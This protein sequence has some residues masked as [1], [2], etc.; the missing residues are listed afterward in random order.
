ASARNH[1]P[2]AGTPVPAPAGRPHGIP[3][4]SPV[5]T[6]C[7]GQRQADDRV[8]IWT[9]RMSRNAILFADGPIAPSLTHDDGS[10]RGRGREP[11]PGRSGGRGETFVPVLAG[12]D[13]T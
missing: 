2:G 1:R 7:L 10:G 6:V 12:Q 3:A 8:T 11:A 4:D 9:G 13:E 5:D